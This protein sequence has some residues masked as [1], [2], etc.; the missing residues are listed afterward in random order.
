MDIKLDTY[1]PQKCSRYTFVSATLIE[2]LDS[3]TS[4]KHR[5]KN[6]H[7]KRKKKTYLLE[8]DIE[9]FCNAVSRHFITKKSMH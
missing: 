9:I 7:D 6:K 1:I 8:E 3:T 5:E 4:F 2:F